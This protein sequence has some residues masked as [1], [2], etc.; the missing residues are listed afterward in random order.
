MCTHN[1]QNNQT[2][3]TPLMGHSRGT[4]VVG[5]RLVVVEVEVEVEVPIVVEVDVEVDKAEVVVDVWVVGDSVVV[6]GKGDVVVAEV[7][8]SVVVVELEV[9]VAVAVG[10]GF[11]AVDPVAV[12]CDPS[13]DLSVQT[14][15]PVAGSGTENAFTIRPGANIVGC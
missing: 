6:V 8:A 3:V 4:R 12:R 13:G 10:H 1:N 9:V 14:R 2:A 5:T 7:L 11:V 15:L